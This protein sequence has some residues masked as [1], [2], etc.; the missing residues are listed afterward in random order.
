MRELQCWRSK[1][2]KYSRR[3]PL[4]LPRMKYFPLFFRRTND[5]N[6]ECETNSAEQIWRWKNQMPFWGECWTSNFKCCMIYCVQYWYIF[7]GHIEH[8]SV[9]CVHNGSH[10]ADHRPLRA[11]F[12][13]RN[14]YRLTRLN[15]RDAHIDMLY[16]CE[17]AAL[18]LTLSIA[19][20]LFRPLRCR[21][22]RHEPKMMF[23]GI[24]V[25]MQCDCKICIRLLIWIRKVFCTTQTKNSNEPNR[26]RNTTQNTVFTDGNFFCVWPL[27]VG[28][29]WNWM[30][31]QW[32]Y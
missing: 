28:W 9:C 14:V 3:I 11:R 7:H 15:Q 25:T 16:K 29:C 5:E 32:H 12:F 17:F 4:F 6:E 8:V 22:M 2:R 27:S 10:P 23:D 30:D 21:P 1:A 13:S 24:D 18:L 19:I 31:I 20:S 26:D